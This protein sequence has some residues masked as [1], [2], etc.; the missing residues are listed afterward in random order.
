MDRLP[1]SRGRPFLVDTFDG[2]ENI[3]FLTHFHADHYKG[4]SSKTPGPIYCSELTRALLLRKF[5]S[6]PPSLVIPL[7]L[8]SSTLVEGV[9]V[10]AFDANHCPG[11][12]SLIFKTPALTILHTGDFRC[13]HRF[14]QRSSRFLQ[15]HFDYVYMDNTYEWRHSSLLPIPPIAQA[16]EAVRQIL[17]REYKGT[18]RLLPPRLLL[19]FSSYCVGKEKMFITISQLFGLTIRT[20]KEKR[21]TIRQIEKDAVLREEIA[22]LVGRE[23]G[24]SSE[25]L[26]SEEGEIL[27]LGGR[28]MDPRSLFLKL[29]EEKKRTLKVIGFCCTGQA[30]GHSAPKTRKGVEIH[31]I[32]YSEH[33]SSEELEEFKKRISCGELIRSVE[34]KRGEEG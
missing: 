7:P 14:L 18:G 24:W 1:Q 2:R 22:H 27:V 8:N 32:L 12:V 28:E 11:S 29:R 4:L 21:E 30:T 20:D 34:R 6:L 31:H 10:T 9:E 25:S 26:F 23:T 16:V 17:Q 5:S 3:H 15:Q 33:S 13:D 19:A